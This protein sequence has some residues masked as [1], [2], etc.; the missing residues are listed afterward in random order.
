MESSAALRPTAAALLLAATCALRTDAVERSA[1]VAARPKLA[2]PGRVEAS[3][4]SARPTAAAEAAAS[5]KSDASRRDSEAAAA[6]VEASTKSVAG[7]AV[8]SRWAA[9]NKA[10]EVSR[11]V[12]PCV[13]AVPAASRV[14]VTAG[15]LLKSSV[16]D[17]VRGRTVSGGKVGGG[18]VGGKTVVGRTVGGK[19]VVGRTVNGMTVRG[20]EFVEA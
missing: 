3:A 16:N 15:I 12:A 10:L 13:E 11:T 14:A 4:D 8:A 20:K 6:T 9:A 17:A 18:T 19:T 1:S 5:K 7:V 2:P